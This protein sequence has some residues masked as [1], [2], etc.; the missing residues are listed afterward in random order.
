MTSVFVDYPDQKC[1]LAAA[2]ILLCRTGEIA[3]S[4]MTETADKIKNGK[5]TDHLIIMI[6]IKQTQ[7]LFKHFNTKVSKIMIFLEAPHAEIMKDV[8][9]ANKRAGA[10][11]VIHINSNITKNILDIFGTEI[12]NQHPFWKIIEE[13]DKITNTQQNSLWR[14][15]DAVQNK[16]YRYNLLEQFS[17]FFKT[18]LDGLKIL[19]EAELV[20]RK[21]DYSSDDE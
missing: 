16:L 15:I 13:H 18:D 3:I 5:I 12:A 19:G 14:G 20:W 17:R 2:T 10:S 7:R 4:P 21:Y 8:D 6:G 9:I 11:H 1:Y